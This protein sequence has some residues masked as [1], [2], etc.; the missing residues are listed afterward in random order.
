MIGKEDGAWTRQEGNP[1]LVK[2]RARIIK[3][4]D[5]FAVESAGTLD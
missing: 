4:L 1:P 5:D 3:P 2:W